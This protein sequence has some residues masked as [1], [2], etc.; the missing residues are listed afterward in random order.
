MDL[1]AIGDAISQV[2]KIKNK[3][4]C[5]EYRGKLQFLDIKIAIPIISFYEPN[6]VRHYKQSKDT[7]SIPI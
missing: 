2:S 1:H 3:S 5:Q 7:P 4:G 6:K